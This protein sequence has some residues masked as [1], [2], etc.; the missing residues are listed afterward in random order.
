MNSGDWI[1][2]A[3]SF[4]KLTIQVADEFCKWRKARTAL[5]GK[6]RRKRRRGIGGALRR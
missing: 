6:K 4:V 2:L 1:N 3:I 5:K